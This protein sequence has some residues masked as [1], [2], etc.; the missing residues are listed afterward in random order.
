M[1]AQFLTELDVRVVAPRLWCAEVAPWNLLAPL[2]FYSARFRGV[3]VVP[4]GLSTDF[5]SI[6][7]GLWN[8]YPQTG[9]WLR[10][11]VLHDAGYQKQLVTE[12]GRAVHLIRRYCD[13]LFDE[14]MA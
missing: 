13:E 12:D 1:T 9:P 14:G 3:F 5:A 2:C 8:L 11:A 10:A 6:P 7:R 4:A